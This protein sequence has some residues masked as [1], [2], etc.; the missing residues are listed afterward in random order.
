MAFSTRTGKMTLLQLDGR[1]KPKMLKEAIDAG[2]KACLK[3]N[4]I[5]KKALRTLKLK[6]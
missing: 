6:E 1:I 3:I 4:E 5:Q 2:F